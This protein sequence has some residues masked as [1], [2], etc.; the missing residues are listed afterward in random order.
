ME[1]IYE[2]NNVDPN[3]NGLLVISL[4]ISLKLLIYNYLTIRFSPNHYFRLLSLFYYVYTWKSRNNKKIDFLAMEIHDGYQAELIPLM[5]SLNFWFRRITK[6]EYL[7][8]AIKIVLRHP[9]QTTRIY[10]AF[11][12]TGESP[13]IGK[14]M[15][16]IEIARSN[17]L[18]VGIFTKNSK[19][20]E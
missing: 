20:M 13:K 14:I 10:T 9:L 18:A 2:S 17:N 6:G 5:N 1:Y 3:S 12:K 11:K 16:G 7:S 19:N 8:K 15:N 4:Y